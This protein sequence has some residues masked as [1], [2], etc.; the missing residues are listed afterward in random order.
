MKFCE[1]LENV[2]IL[3]AAGKMGSGIAL[4]MTNLMT[5]MQLTGEIKSPT[6]N[7]IDLNEEA[8]KGLVKY[9]RTG[10]VKYAEKNI[11]TL[12]DIYKERKDLV[13]NGEIINEFVNDCLLHLNTST[14]L[15]ACKN[16]KTIFEAIVENVDIKV[17]IIN[18]I[19]EAKNSPFYLTN[20]SSIPINILDNECNL[21]GRVIGF[22]FYN[23]PPVQKLVELISS[24]LTD[25]AIKEFSQELGKRLRKKII[26]ANDIAGFIG[27]GHFMRDG[28]HALAEVKT[29]CKEFK[30]YEAIYMMNKVS[31]DFMLRPMGIYQLIDYVGA[32]VFKLIL[33]VMRKNL[34]DKTLEDDFINDMNKNKVLGGQRSNGSQKDGFLKYEKNRPVGIYDRESK[35]YKMFSDGNWSKGLDEKLGKLPTGFY[36]WKSLLV[37]PKRTDKLATYFTNLKAEKTLGAKLALNYLTRSKEIGNYLV[38]T[39]VANNVDD[40]NGVLLNGFY[41]LYG[42]VNEYI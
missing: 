39:K 14:S 33:D 25:G 40:V 5:E 1:R 29:L 31:Q 28:L 26:P 16:S 35:T 22:H 36:P 23:P 19:E 2:S 13:E 17:K 4:L 20:T 12:R 3:G 18:E 42:P 8:L 15:D 37:D 24:S 27:N 10:S 21:S 32:D 30:E 9:I 7:L 11:N 6:L 38:E 41:H 34:N